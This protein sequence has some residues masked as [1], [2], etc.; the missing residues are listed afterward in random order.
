MA[1]EGGFGR[2]TVVPAEAGVSA[3]G[4]EADSDTAANE[5]PAGGGAADGSLEEDGAAAAGR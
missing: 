2:G 1:C 5:E 3:N 4:G